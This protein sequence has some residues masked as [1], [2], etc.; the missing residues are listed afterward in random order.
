M[1]I[2][3]LEKL[4]LNEVVDVEVLGK[5]ESASLEF[6][7]RDVGSIDIEE[8]SLQNLLINPDDVGGHLHLKRSCREW[9][10]STQ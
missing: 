4:T 1:G 10:P 9:N 5:V 3:S 2:E 7:Q 8:V 6:R